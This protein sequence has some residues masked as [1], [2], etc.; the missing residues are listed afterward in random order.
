MR[1][2]VLHNYCGSRQT[3]SD[4][5]QVLTELEALGGEEEP[6]ADLIHPSG[7]HLTIAVRGPF[8]LIIF[9]RA[10]LDPPY[11]SPIARGSGAENSEA[12]E[13]SIGGTPTPVP[14]ERC[15]PVKT[16]LEVVRHY[17]EHETL[18]EWIEWGEQ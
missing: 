7:D 2:W 8:A 15:V 13:F 12:I 3:I 11:L 16:M 10:T 6:T 17:L 14:R 18:P 5:E 9:R 1:E 4:P